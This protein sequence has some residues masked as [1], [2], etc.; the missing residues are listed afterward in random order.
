M[1][2]DIQQPL[3][4]RKTLL[5]LLKSHFFPAKPIPCPQRFVVVEALWPG[6]FWAGKHPAVLD[7][8]KSRICL[9]RDMEQAIR[10]AESLPLSG[11][12]YCRFAW[13]QLA[14]GEVVNCEN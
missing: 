6:A 11:N 8:A 2:K 9:F 12:L 14:V 3:N 4:R 10:A 7:I 13:R 5:Q 1:N